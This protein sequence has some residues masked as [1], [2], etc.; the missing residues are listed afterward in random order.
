MLHNLEGNIY[1]VNAIKILLMQVFQ[2]FLSSCPQND[3]RIKYHQPTA[4]YVLT[5]LV[6]GKKASQRTGSRLRGAQQ[7]NRSAK[8][9][10]G[11]G[12]LFAGYKKA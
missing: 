10:S 6:N 2:K 3:A 8:S 12:S 9:D 5:S 11:T 1:L 7:V 4:H